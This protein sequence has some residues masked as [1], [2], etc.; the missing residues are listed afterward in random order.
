MS[1]TRRQNHL[2]NH[3]GRVSQMSLFLRGPMES[4]RLQPASTTPRL[5]GPVSAAPALWDGQ[6]GSVA[7]WKR[8][9]DSSGDATSVPGTHLLDVLVLAS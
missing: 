4:W 5:M 6:W 7:D 1:L 9:Q 2:L 8:S 3:A